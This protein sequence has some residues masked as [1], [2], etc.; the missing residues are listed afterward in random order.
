L[1][2]AYRRPAGSAITRFNPDVHY[3]RSVRLKGFDYSQAGPHFVTI[4]TRN[5]VCSLGHVLDAAMDDALGRI[6]EYI[7]TNLKN[8]DSDEH[9]ILKS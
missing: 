2:K 6:R 5:R 9:N 1:L 3:R 7:E 8:W 4:C